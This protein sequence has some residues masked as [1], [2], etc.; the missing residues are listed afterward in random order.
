MLKDFSDWIVSLKATDIITWLLVLIGW[1]I[2]QFQ[3]R[4][5]VKKNNDNSYHIH[6]SEMLAQH[7]NEVQKNTVDY[8]LSDGASTESNRFSV[9]LVNSLDVLEAFADRH[10][11]NI[12]SEISKLRDITTGGKFDDPSRTPLDKSHRLFSDTINCIEKIRNRCQ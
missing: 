9:M 1:L 12:S 5:S 8:W 2:A 10:N 11:F 7:L 6:V 3:V 4:Y